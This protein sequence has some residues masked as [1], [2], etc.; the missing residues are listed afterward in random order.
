[1]EAKKTCS[2]PYVMIEQRVDFSRWVPDGFGTADAIVVGSGHLWITDLKFG[3]GVEV[4][5]ENNPQASC[6]A[7]GCIELLD[8]L[9]GIDTVTIPAFRLTILLPEWEAR[10]N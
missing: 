7:L 3:T 10:N 6:Y 9:Y 5:A 8:D 1:M 2:D 4:L